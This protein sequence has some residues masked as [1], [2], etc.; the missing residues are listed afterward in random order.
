MARQ[1]S[2]KRMKAFKEKVE[3]IL[4]ALGGKKDSPFIY[5]WTVPTKAGGLFVSVH[6]TPSEIFSIFCRFDEPQKAK[7][8]MGEGHVS[9]AGKWNFHMSDEKE[10]LRLFEGCVKNIQ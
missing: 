10:I 4:T 6:E 3:K 5:E 8:V 2:E 7:E 1:K 9:G